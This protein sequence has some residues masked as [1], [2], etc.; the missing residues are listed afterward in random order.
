[1]THRPIL[2]T[3]LPQGETMHIIVIGAGITGV[4]TALLL[5][6]EGQNV[7][8]ID[9]LA[10]GDQGQ[11]SFGNAG[12]L[13]SAAVVPVS[14]PGLLAKV[15]K[16]WLD[17]DGPLYLRLGHLIRFL[18]WLRPFLAQATPEGVR[19]IATGLAPLVSDS[20]DQHLALARGTPAA[21]FIEQGPYVFLYAS[22]AAYE[23]DAFGWAIRREQG[24]HWEEWTRSALLDRDPHL[25]EAFQFA[26][27]PDGHGWITWPAAYVSALA[28]A[29][30]QAGGVL[31]QAEVSDL[32][33]IDPASGRVTLVG[34]EVLEADRVILCTGVWSGRL[35]EKLG[36]RAMLEAER[37]YH[38]TFAGATRRPPTPY[39]MTSAK[40]GVTP[41][42][43]GLRVAGLAEFA[44]LDAPAQTAPLDQIRRQVRRL[45]PDIEWEGESEWMGQRPST[46][47]SL[48]LMGR[49]PK[50]PG[51]LF[52]FG[53]QHLG[54][55]MG[56]KLAR[57]VAAEALD[58]GSNLDIAPYAVDRFD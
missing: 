58:R 54:L 30:T 29:F 24:F 27:A 2:S 14:V 31:R 25:G 12:I 4:A 37:G 10:P 52:A 40:L 16:M 3:V 43:P 55:T 23:A 36:H 26:A 13:A 32:T 51:I 6:R 17:R 35:A 22:R 9:R 49:S 1:M 28:E 20:L 44:G 42:E 57:L 18:P 8:L 11:T 21:R 34:G 19:R 50:A 53:G 7:T 15:P 46:P 45:Y 33:P 38:I 56:P 48:P 47:D 39:M 5:A 41:M